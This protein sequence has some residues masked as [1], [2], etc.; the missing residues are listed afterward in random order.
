MIMSL[1]CAHSRRV[2]RRRV[3]IIVP[4]QGPVGYQWRAATGRWVARSIGLSALARTSCSTK[5]RMAALSVRTRWRSGPWN[6]MRRMVRSI[7]VIRAVMEV[8]YSM[9][10]SLNS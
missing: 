3:R 10:I 9:V 6:G 2:Q 4:D 8:W 5:I 1:K 7:S